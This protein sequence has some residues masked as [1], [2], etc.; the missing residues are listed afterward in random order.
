MWSV[1]KG[2]L[3]FN[4]W[5]HVTILNDLV[6]SYKHIDYF[7]INPQK[8]ILIIIIMFSIALLDNSVRYRPI[9]HDQIYGVHFYRIVFASS[10]RFK[11]NCGVQLRSVG[12]ISQRFT[13]T[14][15]LKTKYFRWMWLTTVDPRPY[16]LSPTVI[17]R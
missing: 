3:S 7:N 2:K 15:L 6:P 13:E 16:D 10:V 1:I 11:H 4:F 12:T 14:H 9:N 5:R 8:C 17:C